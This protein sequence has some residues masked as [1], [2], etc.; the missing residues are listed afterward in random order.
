MKLIIQEKREFY[1]FHSSTVFIDYDLFKQ[2]QSSIDIDNIVVK[3][4]I[5]FQSS[6]KGM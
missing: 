3:K 6:L 2:T 1:L 4:H 5:S